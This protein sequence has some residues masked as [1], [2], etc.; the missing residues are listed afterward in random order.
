MMKRLL[1]GAALALIAVSAQAQTGRVTTAAPAY[2]TGTTAPLSLDVNGNLRALDTAAGTT[3]SSIL[4]ALGAGIKILDQDDVPLN[5]VAPA[6]S[7]R[8]DIVDDDS[9]AQACL[10]SVP[11]R[12]AAMFYNDSTA[13]AY[14]LVDE[15]TASATNFTIKMDPGG[16]Y[17][18]P[19]TANGVYTDAISCIWS[20][21]ASG[22]MRV[23]EIIP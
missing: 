16:Y 2:T 15:G 7:T 19:Q 12:Q 3:L 11:T 18:L 13:I 8:S 22:S 6:S 20:A 1:I 14:L 17:E 21:D 23:T 9:P 10:G 5:Y 4:A